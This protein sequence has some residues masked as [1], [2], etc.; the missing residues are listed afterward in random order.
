MGLQLGGSGTLLK[1][2]FIIFI[3]IWNEDA[4]SPRAARSPGS[5]CA[6]YISLLDRGGRRELVKL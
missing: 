6:K 2:C 5:L 1:T 3:L 4:L